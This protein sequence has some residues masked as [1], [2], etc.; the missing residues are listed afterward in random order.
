MA[1]GASTKSKMP[2]MKEETVTEKNQSNCLFPCTVTGSQDLLMFG[3]CHF[4][5]F[6]VTF[7]YISAIK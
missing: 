2:H 1:S 5:S 3:R 6:N 7:G 4:L